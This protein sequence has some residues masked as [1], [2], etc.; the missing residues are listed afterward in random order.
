MD[1]RLESGLTATLTILTER[2]A[3]KRLTSDQRWAMYL[4]ACG[5]I[6]AH[7]LHAGW[8]PLADADAPQGVTAT[9]GAADP[10]GF[11]DRHRP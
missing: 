6:E 3:N 5:K 2:L 4:E 11:H 8:V 10:G 1:K 9:V 7:F